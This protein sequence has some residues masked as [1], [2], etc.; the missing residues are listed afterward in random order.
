MSFFLRRR[1]LAAALALAALAPGCALIPGPLPRTAPPLFDMEEPLELAEEP[2]DEPARAALDKGSFTGI[3]VGDARR[4]LD[5]MLEEPAGLLVARVVENSPADIAGI[6]EGD[7]LVEAQGRAL[8]WPS[9]WRELELETAPGV[10]VAL[11][12]DRAGAEQRTALVGVSRVRAGERGAVERFREERHAGVVLRTATEVEARAAGLGP[13]G[14]AV[15]VGLARSSPWRANLRYRDLIHTAG[16]GRVASPEVVL[17]AVRR[18][19]P[20]GA[21]A[22]GIRREGADLEVEARLTER[23]REVRR[24]SVPLLYSYSNER[25]LRTTSVLLGLFKLERTEAAWRARLLWIFDFGAGDADRL[26]EVPA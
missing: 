16:G 23:E 11:V 3:Q 17:D 22:L 25:G 26:R 19:A 1:P 14:G 15:I 4:S 7:L 5:E 8:R 13:G 2:A 21:I 10:E 9:E 12:Y 6:A 18:A 20:A 24:V